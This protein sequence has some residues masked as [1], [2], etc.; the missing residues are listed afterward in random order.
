[1]GF[2]STNH[3][4]GS[5]QILI[6]EPTTE[7]VTNDKQVIVTVNITNAKVLDNPMIVSL[8]RIENRLPFEDK[9]GSDLKVSVMKLSSS[10]G[11]ELDNSVTYNITYNTN[12][13]GYS[14]N[15]DKETKV[16][17]RFF[18]LKDMI[19]YH[20]YEISTINK[21]Y[22]FDL[23]AGN[24]DEISKLGTEAHEAYTRWAHLKASV[25]ELK[26]EFTQVQV[27]YLRY[28]EKQLMTDKIETRN[29]FKMVG[30]LPN[31]LYKLRFID[32]NGQLIK[33]FTFEVVDREEPVK[34]IETLTKTN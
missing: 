24:A 22:R 32:E 20:N 17:N 18:E 31:G 4:V 15:L 5:E 7:K 30:K 2:A 23:I 21:K 28:F 1:M 10:A 11:G 16:I 29:Y 12:S 26:K 14:D 19:L 6:A 25:S 27:Q 9:L 8:V 3:P 13:N 33:V 34:L